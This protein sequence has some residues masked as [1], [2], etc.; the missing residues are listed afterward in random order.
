MNGICCC[1]VLSWWIISLPSQPSPT[2]STKLTIHLLVNLMST[3]DVVWEPS[4]NMSSIR[5]SGSGIILFLGGR[6]TVSMEQESLEKSKER[7]LRKGYNEKKQNTSWKE[8][9]VN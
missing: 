4:P 3:T 1:A 8:H 2:P 5:S 6:N 9:S 7:Q